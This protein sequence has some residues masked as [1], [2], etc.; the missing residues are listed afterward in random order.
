MCCQELPPDSTRAS[1][2]N[3]PGL[4]HPSTLSGLGQGAPGQADATGELC[5][6]YSLFNILRAWRVTHLEGW[7]I[8]SKGTNF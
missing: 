7:S 2:G 5:Y 3:I 4:C 1:D 6:I 8:S